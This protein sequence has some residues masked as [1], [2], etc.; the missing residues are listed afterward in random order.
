MKMSLALSIDFI[1]MHLAVQKIKPGIGFSNTRLFI[2]LAAFST[3][4]WCREDG[5]VLSQ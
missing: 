4:L 2:T 5:C 1:S 3:P